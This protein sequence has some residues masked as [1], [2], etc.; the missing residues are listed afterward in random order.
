MEIES[1]PED[2]D[3][4]KRS[5]IKFEIEKRALAKEKE[6][7]AKERLAKIEKESAD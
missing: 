7:E 6:T 1:M 5:L 2:L 4:M 3:K